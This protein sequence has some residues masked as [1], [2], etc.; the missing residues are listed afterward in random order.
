MSAS[1]NHGG[2]GTEVRERGLGQREPGLPRL[3][4]AGYNYGYN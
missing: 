1:E 3:G 4:D 2:D